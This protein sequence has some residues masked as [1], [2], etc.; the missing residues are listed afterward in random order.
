MA[1]QVHQKVNRRFL[2]NG[3]LFRGAIFFDLA[4]VPIF[5]YLVPILI[6]RSDTENRI[7]YFIRGIPV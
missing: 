1:W 3:S 6:N 2:I 7:Y 4:F 5:Y